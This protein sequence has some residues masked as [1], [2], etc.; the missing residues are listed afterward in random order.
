M[1]HVSYSPDATPGV[2]AISPAAQHLQ[3]AL[4]MQARELT[5]LLW[6]LEHARHVLVPG[7]IDFWRGLTKLAF[8][9]ALGGLAVTMDDGITTVQAA[10]DSTRTAI[11]VINDHG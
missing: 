2:A 11:A 3:S 6:R 8:D 5:E 10:I 7:P 1:D 4:E 9:S